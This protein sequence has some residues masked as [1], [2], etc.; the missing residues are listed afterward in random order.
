MKKVYKAGLAVLAIA[1]LT[2][3]ALAYS[4]TWD[5]I[6]D[7]IVGDEDG[8]FAFSDAFNVYDYVDDQ[9][10]SPI[11]DLEIVFADGPWQTSLTRAQQTADGYN[12][13]EI[14]LNTIGEIDYIGLGD[15]LIPGL[16][17]APADVIN[18]SSGLIDIDLINP[19]T[20]I[21]RA[22]ILIASDT[23][24]TPMASKAFRVRSITGETDQFTQA[25]SV[26]NIDGW[27]TDGEFNAGTEW[28]FTQFG[29]ATSGAAGGSLIVNLS[30]TDA[31]T[32][33]WWQLDGSAATL[34]PRVDGRL[35]RGQFTVT[36]N[37][38]DPAT[39]SKVYPRLFT[40][41]NTNF[42][43]YNLGVGGSSSYVPTG[44]I[45]L[46]HKSVAGLSADYN[47]AMF[48]Q[49]L[50]A[51]KGGQFV[52][53]EAVVD[54]VVGLDGLFGNVAVI[55]QGETTDFI[56][57]DQ[58]GPFGSGMTYS[59]TADAVTINVT[60]DAA[61]DFAIAQINSGI[62]IAADTL[63]RVVY[64]L[65]STQTG[66]QVPKL[67]VRIFDDVNSKI[68]ENEYQSNP[69]QGAH[70]PPSGSAEYECYFEATGSVGNELRFSFD[71]Q[72]AQPGHTGAVVW[73]RAVI[74]TV[75][76]SVIP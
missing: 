22:V 5:T 17:Y 33:A 1:L 70:M 15:V 75:P 40:N 39:W 37:Q 14:L 69:G 19:L 13:S 36:S 12:S 11:T 25:V 74:Q 21:D 54:Y 30:T 20:E 66:E 44:A 31:N 72:A 27:D 4:P 29:S 38:T 46:F 57:A 63:Y 62:T 7:V 34:I 23:A 42:S 49:D 65:S 67:K 45:N 16:V 55:D 3:S 64:T 41:N 18:D 59:E 53:E 8:F 10:T 35:Y 60:S 56:A 28:V 58:I 43:S 71:L 50:D 48:V 24:T 68:S 76:L 6:P 61:L 52:L 26:V 51:A 47:V 73:D 2:S 32:L 9:D